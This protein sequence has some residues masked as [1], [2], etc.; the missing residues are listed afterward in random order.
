[1][2]RFVIPQIVNHT[3][4]WKLSH[5]FS[6]KKPPF[7]IFLEVRALYK[8]TVI[9]LACLLRSS[10]YLQK[11]E[12]IPKIVVPL[13]QVFDILFKEFLAVFY[14]IIRLHIAVH[15]SGILWH[16]D[17]KTA[18]NTLILRHDVVSTK[19]WRLGHFN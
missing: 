1:M 13:F 12:Q 16:S 14:F 10:G 7:R 5:G 2:T 8:F 17:M 19:N 15:P 11:E 6:F 3:W 4:D 9:S 18:K